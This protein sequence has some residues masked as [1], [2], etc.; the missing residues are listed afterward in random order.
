[1]NKYDRQLVA[2][3]ELAQFYMALTNEQSEAALRYAMRAMQTL[4]NKGILLSDLEPE[5]REQLRAMRK[6]DRIKK[7]P[8]AYGIPSG[9]V[10]NAVN[11]AFRAEYN[12][13]QAGRLIF[14]GPSFYA[15]SRKALEEAKIDAALALKSYPI[16]LRY[17]AI[18][19]DLK[20][21]KAF[22]F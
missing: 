19:K 8:S 13:Q 3:G 6:I 7:K 22:K 9:E 21:G 20:S 10:G 2:K 11:S 15:E 4:R 12:L 5:D 14:L 1:M 17:K 18:D 16:K